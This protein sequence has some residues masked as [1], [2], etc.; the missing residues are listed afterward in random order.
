MKRNETKY[1][2]LDGFVR[3]IMG[4]V[5]FVKGVRYEPNRVTFT[6]FIGISS[7]R[8][9]RIGEA[10]YILDQDHIVW[11]F[12]ENCPAAL[13]AEGGSPYTKN[14]LMSLFKE[15]RSFANPAKYSESL[16]VKKYIIRLFNKRLK[17][18]ELGLYDR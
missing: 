5:S 3:S 16:T 13:A 8:F 15:T 7:S 10:V 17:N 18:G 2:V 1:Q 11:R 14:E 4:E 6:I 12:F 9:M